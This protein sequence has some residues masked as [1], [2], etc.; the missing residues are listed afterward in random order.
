MKIAITGSTGLIGQALIP[1]L[2]AQGCEVIRFSRSRD[3]I[4]AVYWNPEGG[5]IDQAALEG[6]DAIIHLAGEPVASGR[7]TKAKKAR[8]RDSRVK[9]TQLL[10]QTLARLQKKPEVLL[11]GSAVGFYG[12]RSGA[13]MIED[14]SPGEGF[15]AATCVEWEASA[16]P[17]ED[18]GIRVVYLRTGIVLSPGGGALGKML[19]AFKFGLGGRLGSGK[20]YMSWIAMDDM[21]R[22]IEFALDQSSLRGPV[23]F[24]APNPVTNAEFTNT[25]ARVLRRPA[26]L[27]VPAL[28]LRA[29]FGEMAKEA[30]LASTKV[31]PRK[32][33]DSGFSFE[34]TMLE[35]ALRH[36]LGTGEPHRG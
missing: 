6:V 10:A 3:P 31:Q 12:D 22:G 26:F 20:Q 11:C 24:T 2:L 32:L 16:K 5:E 4:G 21:V 13:T 30:L 34:Y 36:L 18:A 8:I 7:W 27:P 9:G 23:N 28:A 19:P 17:A 14:S 35:S 1:R 33:Q 29:I 15:L 25:L